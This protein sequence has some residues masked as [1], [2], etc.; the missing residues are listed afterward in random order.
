MSIISFVVKLFKLVIQAFMHFMLFIITVPI[1]LFLAIPRDKDLSC[2][3]YWGRVK[4]YMKVF[5]DIWEGKPDV[6]Y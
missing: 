3:T 6:K 4:R 1:V 5:K 2:L